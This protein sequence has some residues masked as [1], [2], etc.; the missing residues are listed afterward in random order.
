LIFLFFLVRIGCFLLGFV[1]ED[2][3]F[4]RRLAQFTIESVYR[5]K[6]LGVLGVRDT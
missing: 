1:D 4:E 6:L 3:E 5:N 2:D